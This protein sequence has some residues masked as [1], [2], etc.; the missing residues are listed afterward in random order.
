MLGKKKDSF[1]KEAGKP[2]G[3]AG[4]MSQR[5]NSSLLIRGKNF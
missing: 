3:E 2:G 4:L 5:T 1:I